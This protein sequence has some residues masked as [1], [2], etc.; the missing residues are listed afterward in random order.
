MS[1]R[2][3]VRKVASAKPGK[4]SDGN[5]AAMATLEIP[6]TD[7][8]WR[9]LGVILESAQKDPTSAYW[10]ARRG[11]QRYARRGN[12]NVICEGLYE[13][14]AEEPKWIKD[15][16]AALK[17]LA[18]LFSDNP[19]FWKT[20]P[21]LKDWRE[22]GSEV[23]GPRIRSMLSPY[24]IMKAAEIVEAVQQYAPSDQ[25][26]RLALADAMSLFFCFNAACGLTLWLTCRRQWRAGSL[27]FDGPTRPFQLLCPMKLR[28]NPA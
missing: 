13:T 3:T 9:R 17:A 28:T 26:S 18:R 1:G 11:D 10:E 24:A 4:Q 21:L 2:L 20:H 8:D 5:L 25:S 22:R 19:R 16:N 27:A 6:C 7:D 15:G 12:G 14:V 23:A